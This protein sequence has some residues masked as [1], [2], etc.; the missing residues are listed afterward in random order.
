MCGLKA[1]VLSLYD[2]VLMLAKKLAYLQFDKGCYYAIDFVLQLLL[3]LL[4]LLLQ[5]TH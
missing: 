3:L 1:R 5:Q 2:T 4:Q